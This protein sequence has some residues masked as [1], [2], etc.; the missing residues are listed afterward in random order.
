M[1]CALAG[2]LAAFRDLNQVVAELCLDRS[3]DLPN[4]LTEDD[5]VE[6][7]N[8]LAGAELTEG[9]TVLARGAG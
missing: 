6:L 2:P 1:N 9:P 8:H 4:R 7:L 3:M 5:G